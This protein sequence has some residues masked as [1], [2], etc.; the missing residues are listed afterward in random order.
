MVTGEVPDGVYTRGPRKGKP[1]FRRHAGQHHM[2]IV[3]SDS[4]IYSEAAQHE[5]GGS[6]WNCKGTGEVWAGWSVAEGTKRRTCGR[7]GGTGKAPG[8]AA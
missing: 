4:E 6:C 7:C 2:T 8:A 1:R 5:S 3:V